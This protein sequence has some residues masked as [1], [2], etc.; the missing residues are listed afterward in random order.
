M[1]EARDTGSPG[2]PPKGGRDIPPKNDGASGSKRPAPKLLFGAAAALVVVVVAVVVVVLVTSGGG[3]E[4]A[5]VAKVVPTAYT[6]D[7]NGRGF[8]KIASRQ[9]DQRAITE[10][11]AFGGDA[12]TIQS[13]RYT[14]TQA[15]AQLTDCKS[16]T[17][18]D[19]LQQ[20]LAT[21][22]CTQIGRAAYVSADKKFVGQFFVVNLKDKAGADQ[23]LRTL[24]PGANAGWIL[25]LNPEGVPAFGKGFS[26]AY[27]RNYGHYAVITW[28]QQAGGGQGA[29]L[30]DLIDVSLAVEKPADFLWARLGLA[31]EAAQ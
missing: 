25:P 21:H 5:P 24:D 31:D 20:D 7:Y 22:G 13:G 26:A 10:A 12:K 2:T 3:E 11:E 1:I 14:F 19:R 4:K 27:A 28:V 6:P 30:N 29:T 17:W 8:T 15:A 18:G 9:A 16:A 23:I